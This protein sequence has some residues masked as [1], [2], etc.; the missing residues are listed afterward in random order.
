ME[1][2]KVER[3][4]AYLRPFLTTVR[5]GRFVCFLY[6]EKFPALCA[7]VSERSVYETLSSTRAG[8]TLSDSRTN[9][10]TEHK[11]DKKIPRGA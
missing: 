5:I 3:Y 4:F 9:C 8:A 6:L 7:F 1:R 2:K 11:Q 10:P